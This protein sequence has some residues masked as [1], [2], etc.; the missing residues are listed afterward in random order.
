MLEPRLSVTRV[1]KAVNGAVY[2]YY[3]ARLT[4]PFD[5]TTGVK[6]PPKEFYAKTDREA[7]AKAR[8]YKAPNRALDTTTVFLDYIKVDYLAQQEAR[9][10]LDDVEQRLSWGY[11]VRRR[12]RLERYFLQPEEEVLRVLAAE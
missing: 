11:F 3:R 1:R 2:A 6:P 12:R 9:T 8:A 10:H 7:R 4:F 5:A